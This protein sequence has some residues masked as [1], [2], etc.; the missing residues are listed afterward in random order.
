MPMRL[1][2]RIGWTCLLV[3]LRSPTLGTQQPQKR[4]HTVQLIDVIRTGVAGESKN[5]HTFQ[6]GFAQLLHAAWP[7]T[8]H[9]L[10]GEAERGDEVIGRLGRA[11][12]GAGED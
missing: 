1:A 11:G 6:A 5:A 12:K 9:R 8:K 4:R 3:R 2:K 10:A 7:P